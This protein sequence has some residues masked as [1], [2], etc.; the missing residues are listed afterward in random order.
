MS[1]PKF[2]PG[3]DKNDHIVRDALKQCG[4]QWEN[5][6]VRVVDLSPFR[7][8]VDRLISLGEYL[9]AVEIK[10]EEKRKSFTEGE[11]EFPH[12]VY[13]VSTVEDIFAI[14]NHLY[15]IA[16]YIT[17]QNGGVTIDPIK[18]E[19]EETFFFEEGNHRIETIKE[20]CE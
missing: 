15:P 13:V 10:P 3:R 9:F 6:E 1:R 7:G 20:L 16:S 2:N 17:M 5:L 19:L 14:F 8:L 11:K 12:P 4:Y 18:R